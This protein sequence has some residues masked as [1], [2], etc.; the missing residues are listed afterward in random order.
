[1]EVVNPLVLLAGVGVMLA[2]AGLVLGAAGVAGFG[3]S[4]PGRRGRRPVVRRSWLVAAAIGLLVLVATGWV[5]VAAGAAGA[6]VIVPAIVGS[7]AEADR[8]IARLEG[9]AGFTRRLADLLASGAVGSL[10]HGLRRAA[11][12]CPPAIQS[13]VSALVSRMGP[14]GM[15]PALRAF[16]RD[17]GDP[18]GDHVAMALILRARNGGRGLATVLVNLA[19]DVDDQVRMRRQIK[20]ERARPMNSIRGLVILTVVVWVLSTVFLRQYMAPYSSPDGQLALVV[21]VGDFA[22]AMAWLR[23]LTRPVVGAR[24]LVD[25][26][27]PTGPRA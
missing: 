4:R 27:T 26:G 24:F 19:S 8:R 9:L 1:V 25:P 10:E 16:G 21:I 20:S 11:T 12:G 22:L 14:Q 7:G 17:L 23:R 3:T 6:C 18:A 5:A 15:E 2:L 13:E